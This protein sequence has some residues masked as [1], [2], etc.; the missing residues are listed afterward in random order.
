VKPLI[1]KPRET[2]YEALRATGHYPINH[3]MVVKDELLEDHPG[4]AAGIFEAFTEAKRRYVERLKAG[5][6]ENPTAVDDM[7]KRVMEITGRDP[8]PYGI[9]PNRRMLDEV[10]AS[11]LEQKII[12]RPV[13]VEEL[14]PASTHALAG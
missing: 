1:A 9:E 4:L 11:A 8:L 14:F 13:T 7:H 3:L 10:I 5:T 2:A 6:I 12:T